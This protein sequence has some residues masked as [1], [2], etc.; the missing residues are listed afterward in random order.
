VVWKIQG[1]CLKQFSIAVPLSKVLY[2]EE[3]VRQQMEANFYGPL[4]AVR[5]CLPV[6]R[7]K[8]SGQIILISSGAGYVYT[9]SNV[10]DPWD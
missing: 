9:T 3:E 2:S 4:R 7:E 8:R 6:M 1:Q 10:L 5:A